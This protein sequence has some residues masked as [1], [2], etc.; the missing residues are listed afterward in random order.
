MLRSATQYLWILL[1]VMSYLEVFN[2]YQ[3]HGA[4]VPVKAIEIAALSSVIEQ[5]AQEDSPIQRMIGI[6]IQPWRAR[7]PWFITRPEQ[8]PWN[9]IGTIK[10]VMLRGSCT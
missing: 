6:W 9:N 1:E 4:E 5:I 3:Q 7:K 8:Q 2:R 10:S